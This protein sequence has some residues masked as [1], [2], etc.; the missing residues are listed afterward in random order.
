MPFKLFLLI[1]NFF[2]SLV[3]FSS[4]IS[5]AKRYQYYGTAANGEG[6]TNRNVTTTW[7]GRRRRLGL[8]CADRQ[9]QAHHQHGYFKCKYPHQLTCLRIYIKWYLAD[10]TILSENRY[11]D[12]GKTNKGQ[13]KAFKSF[14]AKLK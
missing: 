10:C 12:T 8:K 14:H 5:H 11:W 4:G 6:A 9:D 3:G 1:D 2:S 7:I 13:K